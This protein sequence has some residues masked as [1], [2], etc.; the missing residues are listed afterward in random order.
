MWEQPASY[1]SEGLLALRAGEAARCQGEQAF[2]RFHLA[3]LNAHHI[4][5]KR[6]D[7]PEVV[8]DVAKKTGLDLPEFRVDLA[9]SS[10]L[11]KIG[12]DYTEGREKY[13][14]F[15]TPTIICSDGNAAFLKMMPPPPEEAVQVFDNL[16][17]IISRMPYVGEIKS[18][19]PNFKDSVYEFLVIHR[20]RVHKGV[21]H[22]GSYFDLAVEDP[23]VPGSYIL[24]IM[25]NASQSGTSLD[26]KRGVKDHKGALQNQ[27]IQLYQ[28]SSA[29]WERDRG[30]TEDKLLDALRGKGEG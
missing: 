15:G 25:C 1:A 13:G 8:L 11:K 16:F 28:I 3:L 9:D 4:E 2:Q 7:K 14:V 17:N 19:E 5:R 27:G 10:H 23:D 22:G 6:I 12:T 30:P 21:E 26:P 29:D 24:N 20:Y 18:P